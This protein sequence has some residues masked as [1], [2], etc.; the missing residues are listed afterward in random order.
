MPISS[1]FTIDYT[2]RRIY[3]SAGTTAYSMNELYSWLMDEV[4]E[5]TTIDDPVPMTA[6]TPTAYTLT[7]GWYIDQYE[8]S[9]FEYL[10]GGSLQTSG[11]DADTSNSGIRLLTFASGGYTN[12]VSGDIGREVGYSGGSP[13]DTGTLLDFNNT[14]RQWLVRVDDTGD[15]F[16]NTS[17][18]IDLDDGTGTG[19]GTLSTASTTGNNVWANPYTIGTLVDNTQIYVIQDDAKI[20]PW[21]STGHIDIL[22]KVQEAGSLIDFGY[23]TIFARHYTILYDHFLADLSSGARTPIPLAIFDDSNNESGYREMSLTD[24]SAAFTVGEVI[25]DDDNA[26]IQGIVTSNTGTAPNIT[27][28]YYLIGYPQTDFS[29]A[30]GTFTGQSSGS[31]ATAVAPSDVGPAALSPAITFTFGATSQDL[32]NGSGSRPYD[33][34]IDLQSTHTLEDLYEY[35]KYVTRRGSTTSLNGHD[36]EQYYAVGDIRLLY[37]GQTGDFTEGLTVTGGTSGATGVIVAD[38]DD[39]TS[40]ALVLRDVA[41]TFED[42]ETITDTSTGSATVDLAAGLDEI[43]PVKQSPFG[44]FAGGQFFGA[45]GV[46]ITNYLAADANDFELIDSTNTDQSPP[47]TVA[48]TVNNTQNGDRV[49]IFKSTGAGSETIDKSQF[50]SHATNNTSGSN[51][52]EIQETIPNDTPSAGTLRVPIRD[53]NNKITGET[54]YSYTSWSGSIFSGVSPTLNTTYDGN[55]TAYVPYIDEQASGTTVSQSITYVTD[56]NI[57]TRVRITGIL[58]FKVTGQITS[59]GYTTTVIRTSDSIYQ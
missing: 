22:L 18:A 10:N 21:W 43:A 59:S 48:L 58:P 54:R 27:L 47:V 6:Q 15:T 51:T 52:F 56:R 55:D 34:I 57:L 28:Q 36:G 11:W 4:D 41:G 23:A 5:S 20:T 31:T 3:H 25:E 42:N 38:H 50:T 12:A 14:T 53:A 24:A 40:G 32:N 26:D 45:R 35:I 16:A 17:T 7:N 37:D 44:T 9:S 49:A 1:D 30:T 46:W 19:A 29:G 13:T 33:V 8:S 2:L 39:G